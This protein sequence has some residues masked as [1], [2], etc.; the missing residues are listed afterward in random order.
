MNAQSKDVE[1]TLGVGKS[2]TASKVIR[3][4]VLALVAVGAV[5][6]VVRFVARGRA[7][8]GPRYVTTEITRGDLRVAVTATGTLEALGTVEVGSEVSGRVQAVYVDYNSAVIKG[9]LLAE[10]DPVSLK[11]ETTQA[12]A[13]LAAANAAVQTAEATLIETKQAR[14][15]A[16]TQLERG[17]VATKDLESARAAHAR[18]EA[19]LASAKANA[20]LSAATL[21]SASW[22]LTKAKV[23][24]PI[25]GIVLSRSVS[26]G[27]TVAAS[28]QT[29]VLFKLAADLTKLELH[30]QIDEADVGRVREGMTAEF[31]VD[32]FPERTF[33]SK[34]ESVRNEAKTSSN[35]VSYEGILSV[36]NQEHLLRPGMTATATITSELVPNALLVSN[37]ALRFTP[38]VAKGGPLGGGPPAVSV[39]P[40][41]P[42]APGGKARKRVYVPNGS[43]LTVVE[44]TPG[45]TDGSRTVVL[46]STLE[47]GA[48]V[49][50]DI[51][52]ATP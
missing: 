17:L 46:D 50:T 51:E 35:V 20:A 52:E 39:T 12:N 19:S 2:R 41:A 14:D 21:S 9:Q 24:S 27:Q 45:A 36:D 43:A 10:L 13:Q 23:L 11:A 44:L 47:P 5:V 22:K 7:A 38:P 25:D 32:A 48:K 3:Y 18:A 26:P 4:V 6:L 49:V 8:G 30:V 31:S 16:E 42:A 40:A 28:F 37:M 1:R 15:R 33:A 34:V 29:P